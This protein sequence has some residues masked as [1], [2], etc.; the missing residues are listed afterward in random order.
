MHCHRSRRIGTKRIVDRN[1]IPVQ[2]KIRFGTGQRGCCGDRRLGVHL[3]KTPP[4]IGQLPGERISACRLLQDGFDQCRIEHGIHFQ[5]QGNNARDLRSR[6][7]DGILRCVKALAILNLIGERRAINRLRRQRC[8]DGIA[9]RADVHA[10]PAIHRRAYARAFPEV[11]DV[12]DGD[13]PDHSVHIRPAIGKHVIIGANVVRRRR[14]IP[15]RIAGHNVFGELG[16]AVDR[17]QER[18]EAPGTG[19]SGRQG[20]CIFACR[21]Q[22]IDQHF[23]SGDRAI[24]RGRGSVVIIVERRIC[25]PCGQR[26]GGGRDKWTE[27]S[28]RRLNGDVITIGSRIPEVEAYLVGVELVERDVESLPLAHRVL[29]VIGDS[30]VIAWP[31][32][33][34]DAG[35]AGPDGLVDEGGQCAGAIHGSA[36]RAEIGEHH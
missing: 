23:A 29:G 8:K 22:E 30:A 25:L 1:D 4:R 6:S 33:E 14:Q 11:A 27:G 31:G 7:A 17:I 18:V 15:D 35:N 10:Q 5:H 12:V 21:A 26:V 28:R 16:L 9:R 13:A 20:Y 36:N 24:G 19:G 2:R 3:S 34:G 32:N